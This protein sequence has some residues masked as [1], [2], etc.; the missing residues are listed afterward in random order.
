MSAM[1]CPWWL[2]YALLVPL[3]RLLEK[4][5]RMLAPL[6]RRGM[7]V[8]EPGCGMGYFTLALARLV[9]PEGRVLAVDLQEKML[10]KLR[11]RARKAG[12]ARR[13][14]TRVC[15][16]DSLGL[17][18]LAG[19]AQ[20][21]VAIH[22]LHETAS[23]PAFLGQVYQALAPGGRLLVVE[24]KLHVSRREFARSLAEA[25]RV[26]FGLVQPPPPIWGHCSL[27]QKD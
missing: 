4:P 17:D 16:E 23:R 7:T 14:Q 13:I 25:R 22:M 6:V 19:Q 26:G 11:R 18:D 20:L 27:L 15:R 24:P 5:E 12:L 9:G 3:R 21:A 8:L 2:G 10:A 1:V